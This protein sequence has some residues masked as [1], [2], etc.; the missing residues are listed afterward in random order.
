MIARASDGRVEAG[1]LASA[2]A[3]AGQKVAL[4]ALPA[5][6]TER[7]LAAVWQALLGLDEVVT[8]DNFFDLG[9]HSLLAMQAIEA[10]EREA[11]KRINP[12]AYLFDSLAQIARAYDDAPATAPVEQSKP[13][14]FRRLFGRS[15]G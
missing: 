11:G 2:P 9:G 4:R 3:P 13:G 10:M 14:I 6:E 5:T 15:R 12:R 8:T 7:Q 1:A